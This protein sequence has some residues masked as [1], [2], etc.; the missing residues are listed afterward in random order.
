[1]AILF[2]WLWEWVDRAYLK[3]L[4][5]HPLGA[6]PLREAERR[7]LRDWLDGEP[8]QPDPRFE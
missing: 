5:P 4:V 7:E 3:V 2:G 8:G 1:M 6:G